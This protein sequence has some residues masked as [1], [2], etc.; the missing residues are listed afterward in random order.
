MKSLS[1]LWIQGLHLLEVLRLTLRADEVYM[2]WHEEKSMRSNIA[3]YIRVS[4]TGQ[5]EAGQRLEIEQWLA[6]NGL[7]DVHWFV[8]KKTGNHF[9]RSAFKQLQAAIFRGEV[10]TIVVWKLDRMSRTMIEGLNVLAG[11]CD[12]GLRVVSVTQQI[13]F[14][15]TLGKIMAAVLLGIAQIENEY[16][17][18]RQAAGIAAARSQGRR[19]GGSAKGRRL[20]ISAEQIATAKRLRASEPDLSVS[21]IAR[22]V[23]I[24]RRSAYRLLTKPELA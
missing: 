16:R 15:G 12:R 7:T 8:D 10:R 21:E 3:C 1:N 24:S 4:S 20:T 9:D 22:S 6:G 19:W 11:W 14:S 5:N 18:E 23:G 13:D 2:T 17:R